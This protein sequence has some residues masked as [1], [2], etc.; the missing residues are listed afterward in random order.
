MSAPPPR[1]ERRSPWVVVVGVVIVVAALVSAYRM[2]H[3]PLVAASATAVPAVD[4]GV[5]A[6]DL[7]VQVRYLT[8]PDGLMPTRDC[9]TPR[10]WSLPDRDRA[11]TLS[12]LQSTVGDAGL[13]SQLEQNLSCSPGR[14]CV[15]RPPL[16]VLDALTPG[17]RSRLYEVLARVDTNPPADDAF[18]RPVAWGPFSA[19]PGLP[20]EARQMIDR[21]TWHHHGV[22]TFSDVTLVCA[23]LPTPDA[24]R[25]FVRAMLTRRTADLALRVETTEAIERAVSAF[26][27][28]SQA[29]VRARL[30]SARAAGEASVPLASLLPEWPRQHM[31][32]FARLDE[33]WTNCFWTALRFIDERPSAPVTDDAVWGA[34][35]EREF[36]RVR[37]DLRVGDVLVLR[38]ASGRR[39]HAATWLLGGYLFSK[40]GLGSLWPWRVVSLDD[41]LIGFP[42]TANME[43]WR[44][45]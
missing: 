17:A 14:G 37:D 18:R 44:R 38:D 5:H 34:M 20:A 26:P 32:T 27:P 9:S 30:G 22:A 28:A 2:R 35:V 33:A 13:V 31:G 36:V 24:R 19:I 15:I 42:T 25:A 40:D 12:L 29:A 41:L 10:P 45:R 8:P 21:L 6:D 11:S 1:P 43:F 4:G 3:T 7:V 16:E 39:V 23:R